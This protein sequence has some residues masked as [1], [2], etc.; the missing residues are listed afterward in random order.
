MEKRGRKIIYVQK[1]KTKKKPQQILDK[2]GEKT[3]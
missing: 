3:V 1:Q 2:L